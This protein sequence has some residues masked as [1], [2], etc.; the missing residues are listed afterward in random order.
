MTKQ[1]LLHASKLFMELSDLFKVASE[2]QEVEAPVV[3]VI[4]PLVEVVEGEVVETPEVE[5]PVEPV[6]GIVS[7]CTKLNIRKEADIESSVLFV[8]GKDSD[9]L[10][11]LEESTDDWYK[12]YVDGRDG[13]CMKKYVELV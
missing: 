1:Q 3:D 7:G 11:N 8:I 12:V 9:V 5:A 2:Q 4:Q 6:L 13:F 10:I